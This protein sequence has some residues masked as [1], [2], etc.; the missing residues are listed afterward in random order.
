MKAIAVPAQAKV[1]IGLLKRARRETLQSPDGQQF[2]LSFVGAWEGFE[3]GDDMTTNKPLM[4]RLAGRKSHGKPIP[5]AEVKA[6]L[7]LK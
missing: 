4:K 3:V 6:E 2:V 1:L 7:G 5:L